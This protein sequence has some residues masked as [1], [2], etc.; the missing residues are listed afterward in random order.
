[1]HKV[2]DIIGGHRDFAVTVAHGNDAETDG[3]ARGMGGGFQRRAGTGEQTKIFG[4]VGGD[5]A[6]FGQVVRA[7]GNDGSYGCGHTRLRVMVNRARA[8]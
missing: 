8:M 4:G 7:A 2:H 5:A 3:L 6:H 1:M